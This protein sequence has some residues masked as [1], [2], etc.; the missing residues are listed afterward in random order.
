MGERDDDGGRERLGAREGAGASEG[1][2]ATVAADAPGGSGSSAHVVWDEANILAT[3]HPAGKDYGH[4]KIDEP[5]TPYV[6][7]LPDAPLLPGSG[8]GGDD[9]GDDTGDGAAGLEALDLG[10]GP[11]RRARPPEEGA[12]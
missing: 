5:K 2:G 11:G 1:A 8:K 10:A 3:F 6:A 7:P 12:V 9:T 4:M